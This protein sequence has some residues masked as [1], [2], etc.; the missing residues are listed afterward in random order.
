M[1]LLLKHF[2]PLLPLWVLIAILTG[3]RD[4]NQSYREALICAA[5]LAL[6]SIIFSWFLPPSIGLLRY[7]VQW[8]ALF[9]LVDR[10]CQCSRATTWRIVIYYIAI[11][12]F[13]TLAMVFIADIISQPVEFQ[14]P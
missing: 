11:T 1:W 6:I 7:P 4:S 13:F 5:G 14:S 10:V 8:F 12:I 2:I 3:S 9:H